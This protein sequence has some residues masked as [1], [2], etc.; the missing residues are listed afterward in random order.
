MTAPRARS[1]LVFPAAA[2]AVG[3]LA[4]TVY[5]RDLTRTIVYPTPDE[6]L[7]ALQAE[8][9]R[10]TGFDRSGRRLPIYFE[11]PPVSWYQPA[12]IYAEAVALLGAPF[13][14]RTF[15]LTTVSIALV[16]GV[17]MFFVLR[18]I[19]GPWLAL[20]GAALLLTAPAHFLLGRLAMDYIYPLPFI[21]FWLWCALRFDGTHDRRWLAGAGAALG[22]GFFTYASAIV[23]MPSL[24]A[25]TLAYLAW[26]GHLGRAW[27][28]I[29]AF[30]TPM[31]WPLVWLVMYPEMARDSAEHYAIAGTVTTG[32]TR[33]IYLYLQS[34]NPGFLFLDATAPALFTIRGWGVFTRSAGV[35]FAAGLISMRHCP[36]SWRLLVLGGL[37]VAAVPA[38]IVDERHATQR[39]LPMVPFIAIVATLGV[40]FLWRLTLRRWASWLQ[41]CGAASAAAGVAYLAFISTTQS[42]IPGSAPYLIG[43]GTLAFA[44]GRFP[45]FAPLGRVVALTLLLST[46][47]QFVTFVRD[48]HDDYPHRS[49]AV[50]NGNLPGALARVIELDHEGTP[51]YLNAYVDL[52]DEYWRFALLSARR[53]DLAAM[54][55][56]YRPQDFDVTALPPA[57]SSSPGGKTTWSTER[58]SVGS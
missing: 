41:F 12:A 32:L 39:L 16:N 2:L 21:L 37:L 7:I 36:G 10:A 43:G 33:K 56:K 50:L 8:S 22:I 51:V 29:A 6:V 11:I 30:L 45:E 54:T 34:F 52:I 15:R 46:A 40:E 18:T 5:S 48:Y 4:A 3:I 17:L 31:I 19:A 23:L 53:P 25:L 13:D 44:C 57:A 49:R 9:I 38:V 42:R 58:I 47:N 24:L 55:A 14:I 26:S 20:T 35:L 1:R 27:L 28:L